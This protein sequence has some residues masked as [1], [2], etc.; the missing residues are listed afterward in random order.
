MKTP[1]IV[2]CI[3]FGLLAHVPAWAYYKWY[4]ENGVVHYT[5]ADPPFDAKNADGSS[6]WGEDADAEEAADLARKQRIEQVQLKIKNRNAP[7]PAPKIEPVPD[8]DEEIPA[9]TEEKAL[10]EEVDQP[11]EN[12]S[13][14]Q[15]VVAIFSKD[16][17]DES[18]CEEPWLL[19]KHGICAL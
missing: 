3:L 9:E 15:R 2:L 4:D 11:I 7:Q 10:D 17:K 16:E 13:L 12:K 6:W 1:A 14:L 18:V 5:E 19:E 8:S